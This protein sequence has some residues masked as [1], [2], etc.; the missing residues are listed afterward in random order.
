MRSVHISVVHSLSSYSLTGKVFTASTQLSFPL[1]GRVFK[2]P[3]SQFRQSFPL[4]ERLFISP[5]SQIQDSLPSYRLVQSFS[6]H[7]L[8]SRV[9]T[10]SSSQ[11]LQFVH[12]HSEVIIYQAKCSQV[13]QYSECTGSF[14]SPYCTDRVFTAS[15]PRVST[16]HSF[17]SLALTSKHSVHNFGSLCLT[18]CS[19][20]RALFLTGFVFAAPAQDRVQSLQYGSAEATGLYPNSL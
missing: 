10:P 12:T 6:S 4:T 8:A 18:E 9:F 15:A 7:T 19:D 16:I 17:T 11:L 14:S 2:S 3:R 13:L 5:R 1:T 20:F